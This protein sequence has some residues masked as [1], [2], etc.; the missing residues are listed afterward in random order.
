MILF[1]RRGGVSCKNLQGKRGIFLT[2]AGSK[3]GTGWV[4]Q[5]LET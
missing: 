2:G 3:R 4:L 5:L 1:A